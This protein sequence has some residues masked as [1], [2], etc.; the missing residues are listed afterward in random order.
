MTDPTGLPD[1]TVY[2]PA[3]LGE[4]TELELMLNDFAV[5]DRP[6]HIQAKVREF[7]AQQ[8]CICDADLL[9]IVQRL[10]DKL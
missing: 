5:E 4:L 6:Q 10:V 7:L 8:A 3:T 1:H 2:R 9:P